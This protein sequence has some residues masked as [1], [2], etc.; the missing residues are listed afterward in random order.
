[1]SNDKKILVTLLLLLGSGAA[2]FYFVNKAKAQPKP[3][4]KT[5]TTTPPSQTTTTTP[6]TQAPTAKTQSP[7]PVPTQKIGLFDGSTYYGTLI[8]GRNIGVGIM[9]LIPQGTYQAST[10]SLI[11]DVI[12]SEY[13]YY[14][15][16]TTKVN[17]SYTLPVIKDVNV[18]YIHSYQ[19]SIPLDAIRELYDMKGNLVYGYQANPL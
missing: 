17:S 16:S 5:P 13:P 1:M 15:D 3:T 19:V 10:N 6:T 12:D 2:A 14:V 11:V 4:P 7:T 18:G 9:P 8:Y